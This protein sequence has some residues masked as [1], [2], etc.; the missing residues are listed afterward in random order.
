MAQDVKER[1]ENRGRR[2][3][4]DA[5]E[6]QPHVFDAGKRNQAFEIP[7]RQ[8]RQ[9]GQADAEQAERDE[10]FRDDGL[11]RRRPH[12]RIDAQQAV[13]ADVQHDAR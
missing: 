7:F 3:D 9:G 8:H 11:R 1:P 12:N 4:A 10:K 13:H 5:D 6:Q 2:A